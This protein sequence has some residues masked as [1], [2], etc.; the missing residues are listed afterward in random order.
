MIPFWSLFWQ[1]ERPYRVRGHCFTTKTR[2]TKCRQRALLTQLVTSAWEPCLTAPARQFMCSSHLRTWRT[3]LLSLQIQEDNVFW[4]KERCLRQQ[5]RLFGTR[6]QFRGRHFFHEPS[7]GG[8]GFRM[9]QAHY[10]YCGIYFY[11]YYISSTSDHQA[12]EP[13]RL[14]APAVRD[15]AIEKLS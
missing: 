5:S 10:T 13:Q 11:Y 9:I 14:R 4:R 1:K 3:I 2:A 15:Q 6:D 12:L 7:M 8:D